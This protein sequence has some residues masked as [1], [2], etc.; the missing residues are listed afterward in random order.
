M[1]LDIGGARE[2][3]GRLK[4]LCYNTGGDLLI[5]YRV[6]KPTHRY[7]K[8]IRFFAI[9]ALIGGF[10]FAAYWLMSLRVEPK[11]EISNSPPVKTTAKTDEAEWIKIDKPLFTM[12]LPNGWKEQP[13]PRGLPEPLPKYVFQKS[14]HVAQR[15]DIYIDDLP[16][17]LAVNQAIVV[18]GQGDRLSHDR[19][20][21]NCT[22]YTDAALK[23]PVTATAPGKWQGTAFICDMGK[24]Q[25]QV[26]GTMSTEGVNQFSLTGESAGTRKLFFRYEDTDVSPDFSVLYSILDRFRLK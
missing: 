9:I 25:H 12:E 6:G 8:I 1:A 14:T 10:V 26:V 13:L 3:N 11:A 22:T 20:S 15:L 16:Y 2:T 24:T 17:N 18:T 19:V 21:D 5:M 7:Q 23:N 4:C